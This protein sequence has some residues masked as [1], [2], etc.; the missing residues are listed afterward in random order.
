MAKKKPQK[1]K[2]AAV[3]SASTPQPKDFL[4][5]V[6]PTVVKF[7]T[8]HAIVGGVYRSFM[9][10]RGYPATTESLALLRHLGEKSGV[11][12]TVYTRKVTAAEEKQIIQNASSKNQM[13]LS[14]SN[15]LRQSVTAQANIKDMTEMVASMDRKNEPLFHCAVFIGLTARD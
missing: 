13:V 15:D 8:D 9:A 1:K 3:K 7:N 14:S 5:M 12:L 10:L 6:A 4:D 2:K 11:S